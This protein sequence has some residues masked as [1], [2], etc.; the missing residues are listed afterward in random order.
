V[1]VT[2]LND[3]R[4][5][6]PVTKLSSILIRVGVADFQFWITCDAIIARPRSRRVPGDD[7]VSDESWFRYFG[8][9]HDGS[10]PRILPLLEGDALMRLHGSLGVKA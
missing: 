9:F 2:A 1:L 5:L 3:A 7:L 10:L 8:L 6:E 4:G